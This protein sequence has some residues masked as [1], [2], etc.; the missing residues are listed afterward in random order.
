MLPETEVEPPNAFDCFNTVAEVCG[1]VWK[2]HGADGL[3]KLLAMPGVAD[4][5]REHFED[6]AD[7]LR[8]VGLLAAAEIVAEFAE[9]LQPEVEICPH[10]PNTANGRAW[11]QSY[12]NRQYQRQRKRERLG[13]T[14]PL[15]GST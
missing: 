10:D 11:M 8:A 5:Y 15:V 13:L 12:R 2:Q 1:F 6:A 4:S 9:K 3:R 7:D 14:V